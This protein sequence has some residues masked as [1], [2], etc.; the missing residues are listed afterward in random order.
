MF[1]REIYLKLYQVLIDPL[2]DAIEVQH[3]QRGEPPDLR[4]QARQLVATE[5]QPR[6]RGEPPDLRRQARQP[7]LQ[8]VS[9]L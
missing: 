9:I 1:Y 4:R 7:I 6:Q 5:I 3:R 8:C 2:I